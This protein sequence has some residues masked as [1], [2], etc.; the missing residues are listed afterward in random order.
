[1]LTFGITGCKL[2]DKEKNL[3]Q[4]SSDGLRLEGEPVQL[5]LLVSMDKKLVCIALIIRPSGRCL[6]GFVLWPMADGLIEDKFLG[7]PSTAELRYFEDLD[8]QL[9]A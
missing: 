8:A 1:M 2:V 7:M 3:V 9:L 4:S 6:K 5:A